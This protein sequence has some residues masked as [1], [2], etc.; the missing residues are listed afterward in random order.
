MEHGKQKESDRDGSGQDIGHQGH[1][2]SDL[3]PPGRLLLLNFS[4]LHTVAPAAEDQ[5]FVSL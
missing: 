5:A 3:F 4:E 2:P 1:V